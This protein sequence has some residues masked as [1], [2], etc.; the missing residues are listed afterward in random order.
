MVIELNSA[1][2]T[3]FMD[4]DGRWGGHESDWVA[5]VLMPET[6]LPWRKPPVR[7]HETFPMALEVVETLMRSARGVVG[8]QVRLEGSGGLI[9][10]NWVQIRPQDWQ[11]T[12]PAAQE[13]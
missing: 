1:S 5:Y 3:I 13:A 7:I 12:L 6:R 8:A 11:L 2:L 4:G 10:Y 9:L